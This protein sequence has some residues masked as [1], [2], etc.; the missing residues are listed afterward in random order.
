MRF[1]QSHGNNL[2][3]NTLRFSIT[4]NR[5]QID[6]VEI[7]IIFDSCLDLYIRC[8]DSGQTFTQTLGI[9]PVTESGNL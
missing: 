6:P 2:A 3:G 9:E 1:T 7:G 8:C 4:W 5:S